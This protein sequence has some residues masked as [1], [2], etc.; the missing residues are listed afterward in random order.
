MVYTTRWEI[1]RYAQYCGVA[2]PN[3]GEDGKD[4]VID[5]LRCLFPRIDV[6]IK[7][8]TH[9]L[10][11]LEPEMEACIK[12]YKAAKIERDL[13]R[14]FYYMANRIFELAAWIDRY[15]FIELDDLP[16]IPSPSHA[17]IQDFKLR[18][19]E[20][21]YGEEYGSLSTK[22][23]STSQTVLPIND[24]RDIVVLDTSSKDLTGCPEDR[25]CV[26]TFSPSSDSSFFC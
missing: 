8:A 7:I 2:S 12:E 22:S 25:S 9:L 26:K 15:Q 10:A 11:A 16:P 24:L 5:F 23:R 21:K 18:Y 14:P 17:L 4:Y 13:Y 19:P 3:L 20:A 6:C 1:M